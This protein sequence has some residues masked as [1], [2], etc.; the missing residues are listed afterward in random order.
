MGILQREGKFSILRSHFNVHTLKSCMETWKDLLNEKRL[1]TKY[2]FVAWIKYTASQTSKKEALDARKEELAVIRSHILFRRWRTTFILRRFRKRGLD[3]PSNRTLLAKA[4]A[5]WRQEARDGVNFRKAGTFLTKHLGSLSR[6]IFLSWK[7][8]TKY[9]KKETKRLRALRVARTKAGSMAQQRDKRLVSLA[10]SAWEERAIAWV[11]KQSVTRDCDDFYEMETMK[12]AMLKFKQILRK[13]QKRK[14]ASSFLDERK[15][16]RMERV[17]YEWKDVMHSS[18]GA[19]DALRARNILR[20]FRQNVKSQILVNQNL[21]A[22]LVRHDSV[23]LRGHFSAWAV[24]VSFRKAKLSSMFKVIKKGWT[25]VGMKRF[26][27]GP[28]IVGGITMMK[29]GKKMEARIALKLGFA[30]FVV[31]KRDSKTYD[32]LSG[33]LQGQLV[34]LAFETWEDATDVN[35]LNFEKRRISLNLWKQF[36]RLKDKEHERY[37]L[38][39]LQRSSLYKW[40]RNVDRL[41]IEKERRLDLAATVDNYLAVKE[42]E[43]VKGGFNTLLVFVSRR[44]RNR[45]LIKSADD[46]Y[47][48]W[49]RGVGFDRLRASAASRRRRREGKR[50]AIAHHKN[51]QVRRCFSA[52]KTEWSTSSVKKEGGIVRE[53]FIVT[54]GSISGT[55]DGERGEGGILLTSVSSPA[56]VS[57]MSIREL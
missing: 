35:L 19:L 3:A 56:G 12:R 30:S 18:K 43:R 45:H 7:E 51:G 50:M 4:L 20:K 38:K 39:R 46:H 24:F 9:V 5:M 22:L 44:V 10:F 11:K 40:N 1:R 41:R 28:N 47:E 36:M 6:K 15:E 2:Y 31:N 16:I 26:K 13:R 57:K 55:E 32:L 27:N 34:R 49:K 33:V 52:F 25:E 14:L 23:I 17:L 21:S 42:E 37:T 48:M 8:H 53:N 54:S 29:V